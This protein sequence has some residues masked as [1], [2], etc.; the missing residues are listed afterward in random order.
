MTEE[1]PETAAEVRA[2]PP[3][4]REQH[5]NV[6]IASMGVATASWLMMLIWKD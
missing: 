2:A 4:A 5:R 1:I 6:A 3:E